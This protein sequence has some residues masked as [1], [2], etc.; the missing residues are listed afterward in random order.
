[1][2][3]LFSK[4]TEKLFACNSLKLAE[5]ASFSSARTTNRFPSPRCASTIQRRGP[6]FSASPLEERRADE[7]V[8]VGEAEQARLE[9]RYEQTE[10]HH[11]ESKPAA[12]I[13]A[14]ISNR[15]ALTNRSANGAA[16]T[17]RSTLSDGL[18]VPH[19]A[20]EGLNVTIAA[21]WRVS[22]PPK[23][24][25]VAERQSIRPRRSHWRGSPVLRVARKYTWREPSIISS[26][27]RRL[28]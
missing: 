26:W 20:L 8:A 24:A 1:M 28:A 11:R 5:H 17:G 19:F 12:R 7:R 27:S 14:V 2:E 16:M 13:A 9:K 22:L 25:P 4:D 18:P 3:R 10:R 21:Q 23:H 6:Q 15:Y